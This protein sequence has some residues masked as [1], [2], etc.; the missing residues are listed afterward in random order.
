MWNWV[1][2][3]ANLHAS[4]THPDSLQKFYVTDQVFRFLETDLQ[5]AEL[6]CFVEAALTKNSDH[7]RQKCE[8]L[9]IRLTRDDGEEAGDHSSID[10]LPLYLMETLR[11]EYINCINGIA[12]QNEQISN[13][14][15]RLR[16]AR[17]K[18]Q[19][20]QAKKAII[21]EIEGLGNYHDH[22]ETN[23][24][25]IAILDEMR[26]VRIDIVN[27]KLDI[28]DRLNKRR[29]KEKRKITLADQLLKPLINDIQILAQVQSQSLRPHNMADVGLSSGSTASSQRY[30]EHESSLLKRR[31]RKPLAEQNGSE[32][33]GLDAYADD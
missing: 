21:N 28:E 24:S 9:Q 5:N 6:Y 25:L 8:E 19:V 1:R 33:E 17:D 32:K 20:L 22:L 18:L 13:L 10:T 2:N 7:I 29:M 27:L 26:S 12:F 3:L 23:G 14:M 31:I 15:S 11:I 16:E 30:G 4:S